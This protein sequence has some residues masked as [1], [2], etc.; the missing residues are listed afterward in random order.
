[1]PLNTPSIHCFCGTLKLTR[2][3]GSELWPR[4]AIIVLLLSSMT[5]RPKLRCQ[6]PFRAK[7]RPT[8]SKK[9]YSSCASWCQMRFSIFT[10]ERQ[11]CDPASVLRWR[12]SQRNLCCSDNAEQC[13]VTTRQCAGSLFD[14]YEKCDR[15]ALHL[16]SLGRPI[17]GVQFSTCSMSP[18]VQ[19]PVYSLLQND[20]K[21]YTMW[22]V[23]TSQIHSMIDAN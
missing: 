6:E 8:G 14:A 19:N 21:R 2:F 17:F 1:M 20:T 5:S 18:S 10:R 13:A 11:R 4:T 15:K 12:Q 23:Q 7:S 16:T 3:A 9:R 22:K